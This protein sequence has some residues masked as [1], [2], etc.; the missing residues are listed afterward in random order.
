MVMYLPVSYDEVNKGLKGKK[1]LLAASVFFLPADPF[2]VIS[3]STK[4]SQRREFRSEQGGNML[5]VQP[6][7]KKRRKR[8]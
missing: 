8:K 2:F 7:S 6:L 1:G 4:L 5:P 3:R